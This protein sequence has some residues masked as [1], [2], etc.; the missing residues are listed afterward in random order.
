MYDEASKESMMLIKV[1]KGKGWP[2]EEE[3][4]EE[5]KK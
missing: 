5:M 1:K 3:E 2:E 4:T